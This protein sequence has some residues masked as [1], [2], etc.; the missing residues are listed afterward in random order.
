MSKKTNN[1][2]VNGNLDEYEKVLTNSDSSNEENKK[3]DSEIIKAKELVNHK[4]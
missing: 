4:E 3:R 1:T 2:K